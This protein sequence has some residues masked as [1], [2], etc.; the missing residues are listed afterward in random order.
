MATKQRSAPSVDILKEVEAARKALAPAAKRLAKA[1]GSLDPKAIPVGARADLLYELRAVKGMVP[2][3]AAPFDDAVTPAVK[4]LEEDFIQ[5]LMVGEASGVQGATARVQVTESAVPVV[6]PEGWPKLYAYIKR[7]GSFELL[8][9]A[10]NREAV[11]E[12]W[13]Q[14]KQIPGVT[15][16]HAKRVSCTK[17]GKR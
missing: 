9:R 5:T 10:V 6:E 11:K 8:N 4:A 13:D 12:R 7:T 14:K 1:L 17:L 16:F 15:A 2:A 3:L